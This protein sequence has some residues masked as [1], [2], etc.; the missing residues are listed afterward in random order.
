MH[1]NHR[2]S[3]RFGF[4]VVSTVVLA[5]ACS[6]GDD[7]SP[8]GVN[9]ANGGNSTAASAGS[10]ETQPWDADPCKWVSQAEVETVLGKLDR[11]AFRNHDEQSIRPEADGKV[12]AYV[13]STTPP[14]SIPSGVYLEVATHDGMGLSTGTMIGLRAVGEWLPPGYA[15]K[16]TGVAGPWDQAAGFGKRLFTARQ[17]DAAVMLTGIGYGVPKEQLGA[18]AARTLAKIPDLPTLAPPPQSDGDMDEPPGDPCSFVTAA[19]AEKVLGKLAVAP[20]RSRTST[21]MASANGGS[22]S[23][24]TPKHRVL[25]LTPTWEGGQMQVKMAG[26]VSQ[27]TSKILGGSAE[28][29]T[30]EGPWDQVAGGPSGEA[31]FLKGDQLIAMQYN[32][33]STDI[34]G[35]VALA[36]IALARFN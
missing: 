33:S 2:G 19:E 11:P 34:A 24:R 3:G 36:R 17:G 23:Y 31:Y 22:C 4:V 7:A 6:K 15:P 25:V 14:S 10:V 32:T 1:Q 5:I 30:L 9:P 20:Y 13:V 21:S 16:D 28:A 27:Q 12:C 8:G 29:D 26:I 18:L 35:A